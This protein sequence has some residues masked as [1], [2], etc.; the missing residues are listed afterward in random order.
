MRKLFFTGNLGSP[1]VCLALGVWLAAACAK[2]ANTL[3]P[4]EEQTAGKSSGG[5]GG[6]GSGG[7]SGGKTSA[8]GGSK[9]TGG[10]TS[11]G[12]VPPDEDGGEG[13]MPMAGTGG[14]AAPMDKCTTS[15]DCAQVEG[16]CFVCEDTGTILDC[17]DK[18]APECG[19]ETLDPCETCE[20]GDEQDCVELDA[21]AFS[22]GK[23]TCNAACDG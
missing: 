19:N 20:E 12:G 8:F 22:G 2:E 17:V 23:A 21:A 14:S 6:K 15:S 3:E 7:S 5:S 16:S 18:G 11:M 9:A 10:E 4:E 1:V 13:P